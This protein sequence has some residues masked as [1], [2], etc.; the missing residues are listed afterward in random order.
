MPFS[1]VKVI[2]LRMVNISRTSQSNVFSHCLP[3]VRKLTETVLAVLI[4]LPAVV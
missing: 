2:T 4:A 3:L 1:G